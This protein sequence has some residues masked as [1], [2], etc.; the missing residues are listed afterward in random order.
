MAVEI[1]IFGKEL[2]S[3]RS[4]E[5]PSTSLSDP[6]VVNALIS[7]GE[8]LSYRPGQKITP[9]AALS[10]SAF[11]R[12]V[13]LLSGHI[14]AFPLSVYR[15]ANGRREVASDHPV[16]YLLHDQPNPLYTSFI[17]REVMMNHLL[18][19]DGNFYALIERDERYRPNRLHLLDP[20]KVE[21][22]I[23]NGEKYYFVQGFKEPFPARDII[24]VA[25]MGYDGVKGLTPLKVAAKTLGYSMTLHQFGDNFFSGG[26]HM[27]GI[28]EHPSK[29]TTEQYN[30]FKDS[31]YQ[32]YHGMK[33]QGKVGILQAGAKYSK[34]GIAPE[35]AQFLQ[36]RQFT[37]TDIARFL[38]VPP[39]KIY[40][41]SKS[42]NNNIEHQSLEYLQD[43]LLPWLVRSEQEFNHKLFAEAERG[44]Y[45][46]KYNFNGL[47]RGDSTARS[48]FYSQAINSGWMKPDE[49]RELEDF[50]P[51]GGMADELHYPVN[52]MTESQLNNQSN[53][54]N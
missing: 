6:D 42:T 53:E 47:L 17:F 1:K 54:Q 39:H 26:A 12:G 35:E 16:H 23:F 31:W 2:F 22:V 33:N 11:Y 20:K 30:Q 45:Y 8:S 15:K 21:V 48:A 7:G 29:M 52:T 3:F 5:N 14:A 40:D 10:I 27:A 43:S 32:S 50:N 51:V 18:L 38:G 24:H 36:S 49:A 37:V 19:L 25:G 28:V 46:T 4:L 44:T 13:A 9:D 34:I 41:L